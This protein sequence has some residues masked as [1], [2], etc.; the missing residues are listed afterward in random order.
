VK[1]AQIMSTIPDALPETFAHQLAELQAN[2]PPMGWPFVRRRMQAELGRGWQERFA[3]FEH[4]SAAAASLDQV[5][6]AAAPGGRAL[7]CKLQYSDM[8]SVVEADL[9]QLKIVFAIWRRYDNAVDPS[10]M[11]AELSERL[12]EELDYEREARHMGLYTHM[13]RR[14][15]AVHVPAVLNELS[16][17]RLLTMTWLD[18]APLM[19]Y[20][21]E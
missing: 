7:A 8:R 17:G 20:L 14:E 4:S 12:H 2:A 10:E 9:R 19:A 13:L 5:H 16:T 15:R 21:E 3:D 6:R 1:V 11:H 18:G